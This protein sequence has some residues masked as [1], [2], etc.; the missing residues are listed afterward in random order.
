MRC[1]E[2]IQEAVGGEAKG[3]QGM[4]G[5]TASKGIGD[6]KGTGTGFKNP[7]RSP[8]LGRLGNQGEGESA[9]HQKLQTVPSGGRWVGGG[10]LPDF[11]EYLKKFSLLSD[12]SSPPP[13]VVKAVPSNPTNRL[14]CTVY[15]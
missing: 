15:L 10:A 11:F 6:A 3:L 8:A 9:P 5:G 7:K 4:I 2:A 12:G 13:L 14:R 1:R